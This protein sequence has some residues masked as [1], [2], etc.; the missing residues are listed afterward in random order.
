MNKTRR[1][2]FL[3]NAAGIILCVL[4]VSA[5]IV[6]Y[7]PVWAER[8]APTLL[9][10]FALILMLMATVPIVRLA[11]QALKSPAAYLMWLSAFVIFFMLSEIA[12]DMTVICFVGFVSNLLGAVFFKL[13]ERYKR[14][15]DRENEG[16]V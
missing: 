11:K 14:K 6:F 12:R 2:C 8:G 10:G 1:R 4:P 7:F 13:A 5:S 3:M 9:S 16:Q 15:S